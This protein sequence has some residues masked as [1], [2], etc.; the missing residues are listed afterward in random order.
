[1]RRGRR[2]RR[3]A[4]ETKMV[5]DSRGAKLQVTLGRAFIIGF[6]LALGMMA[7]GGF[8]VLIVVAVAAAGSSGG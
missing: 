2:G 3:G 8:I 4:V 6:G 7:G 5:A 1:M